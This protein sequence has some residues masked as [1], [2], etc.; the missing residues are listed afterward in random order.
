MGSGNTVLSLDNQGSGMGALLLRNQIEWG[1]LLGMTH[2]LDTAGNDLGGWVWARKGFPLNLKAYPNDLI[3]LRQR[4]KHRLSIIKNHLEV[5]THPE[6]KTWTLCGDR[7]DLIRIADLEMPLILPVD[8]SGGD[9]RKDQILKNICG[10]LP[11]ESEDDVH[12][13]ILDLMPFMERQ[14]FERKEP[15][16]V[17]QFMLVGT[18][19]PI[20][21][22]FDDAAVMTR[23]GQTLGGWKYINP[24]TGRPV[25]RDVAPTP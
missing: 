17:G 6:L 23:L 24:G 9:S 3:V 4:L 16:T 7:N 12:D 13:K 18:A 19:W 22:D 2:L 5:L 1:Y 20:R 21:I 11:G 10:L 15:V 14:L 25:K 8:V